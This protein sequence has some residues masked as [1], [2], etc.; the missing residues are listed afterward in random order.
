MEDRYDPSW[1]SLLLGASEMRRLVSAF[2]SGIEADRE[3]VLLNRESLDA[4]KGAVSLRESLC[5]VGW[6]AE[7][8]GSLEK[9]WLAKMGMI[10]DAG[11]SVFV[12]PR[13]GLVGPRRGGRR[14]RTCCAWRRRGR[15][16]LSGA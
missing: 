3:M 16:A 1:L 9:Y 12:S 6:T 15:S 13:P 10:E 2:A 8:I 14:E 4:S 11:F 7:V 5:L